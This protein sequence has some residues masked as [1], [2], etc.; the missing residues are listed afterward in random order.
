MNSPSPTGSGAT[1]DSFRDPHEQP[2]GRFRSHLSRLPAHPPKQR[3]RVPGGPTKPV[4]EPTFPPARRRR[5]SDDS[6]ESLGTVEK[7]LQARV[8]EE[9]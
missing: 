5:E 3:C 4:D 9:R 1:A 8:G 2:V 7:V 6:V